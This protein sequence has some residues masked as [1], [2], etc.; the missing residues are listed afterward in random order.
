MVVERYETASVRMSE[1][2]GEKKEREIRREKK[3]DRRSDGGK[4]VVVTAYGH[5]EG[6]QGK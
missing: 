2:R 4:H 3:N 6:G 1:K 5:R